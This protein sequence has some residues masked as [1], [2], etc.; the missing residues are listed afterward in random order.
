M[1]NEIASDSRRSASRYSRQFKEIVRLSRPHHWDHLTVPV[2]FA[3][4]YAADSVTQVFSPIA[5]WF[6]LYCSVPMNLFVY[7]TNDIFDT[8]TDSLNP[9]KNDT[10]GIETVFKSD[11]TIVATIFSSGL[12]VGTV[13]LVTTSPRVLLL[14]AAS[15][16][17]ILAYN[18]PPLRLK[19]VPFV[20]SI[21]NGGFFLPAVAAYVAISG[22]YPPLAA[23][24]GFWMWAMGYHTL[25]ALVDR[26]PDENAGLQTIATVLG[27]RQTLVYCGCVWFISMFLIATVNVIGGLLFLIYPAHILYTATT[28][29][30]LADALSYMPKYNWIVFIPITVWGFW[31]V[32][33]Q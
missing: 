31:T 29:I 19:Q 28:D 33:G 21:V 15:M 2:I 22:S 10:D 23:I 30:E 4:L 6:I 12:L 27:E 13:A 14:L 17:L 26:K 25:A 9:R 7:G 16:L 18:A 8:D 11:T 32:V 24:I 5:L 20:D 3:V 1:S